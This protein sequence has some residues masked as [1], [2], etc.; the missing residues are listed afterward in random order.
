VK[1][2]DQW[3][4]VLASGIDVSATLRHPCY[5]YDNGYH[6]FKLAE[7]Q[8]TQADG[9]VYWYDEGGTGIAD[10]IYTLQLGIDLDNGGDVD[11]SEEWAPALT[12][13]WG[14]P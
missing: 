11:G 5:R 14:T 8:T 12:L 7:P 2:R 9:F 3:H 13:T 1:L 10:V 6:G 4:N